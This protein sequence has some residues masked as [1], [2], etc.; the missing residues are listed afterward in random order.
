MAEYSVPIQRLK[1]EDEKEF[2]ST[3]KL[4]GKVCNEEITKSSYILDNSTDKQRWIEN[5]MR[6]LEDNTILDIE[7]FLEKSH[8]LLMNLQTMSMSTFNHCTFQLH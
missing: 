1:T 8:L 6:L 7:S 5:K 2:M 4:L 3:E